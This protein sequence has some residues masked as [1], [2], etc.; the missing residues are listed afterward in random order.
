MNLLVIDDEEDICDLISEIGV[1]HGMKV[2]TT[3]APEN[4]AALVG[5]FNPDLVMLDLMMPNIDGVEL[6]RQLAANAK[7]AKVCLISGS[8][9]RVLSSARRL[10]SA[11]GLDVIDALEKPLSIT[12]L[13]ALFS[14]VKSAATQSVSPNILDAIIAGQFILYYQPVIEMKTR[15]VKGAEALIRWNHPARGLL[16]PD[17]FL[18]QVVASGQMPAMTDF[19]I[20]TAFQQ[21]GT[22]RKTMP[23]MILSVNVTASIL[24]DLELPNK[25]ARLCEQNLVSAQHLI[26]EVTESE[27]MHDVTSTLDVLLRMRLRNVGV[28]ID[29]FG[30]GHSSLRELKR[31]PFSEIKI[32]RSFV[33]DLDKN[34]DSAVIA[35]SIIELGHNLGLK[36]IA[37]G[38]ETE[39]VWNTLLEKGCDYAQG[40]FAGRPMPIT[41]FDAWLKRWQLA[42]A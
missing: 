1:R 3:S 13:N 10:A 27:A 28:S 6:L 4:A 22:W 16:A 40:Y 8:D 37:E 24:L 42:S 30:T 31:M 2:K 19:V 14:Q 15:R 38:I 32:D 9:A 36:V 12:A 29:D 11:H 20:S 21:L 17:E 41:E 25:I 7:N 35:Q 18:D 23:D 39:S 5:E 34:K 33:I 26:L